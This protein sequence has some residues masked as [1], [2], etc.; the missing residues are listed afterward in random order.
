MKPHQ[1]TATAERTAKILFEIKAVNFNAEKPFILTSGSASP[2]YIDCRKLI[3]FPRA[4]RAIIAMLAE[5]VMN[6]AGHEAFDAI[7]GGET[8]GISYAAWMSDA[9]D[10]PMLYVRKQ[11]K[12]FGRMA[13]IEG[14]LREG[15]RVLLVE[16]LQSQGTSKIK[17]VE[18]LRQ[19]GAVVEHIAVVFHYDIFAASDDTMQK[20]GVKLHALCTWR[21]ALAVARAN[22]Y[23]DAGTLDEVEKFLNAPEAWSKAHGG[24]AA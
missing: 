6:S 5:T 3:S 7:A 17:F 12:G 10:L 2:V 20:L 19:A 22:N 23:F 15:Q 9:F 14:D 18:A 16:D 21:D 24:K 13:Q 4:R 1:L 8:A 11:P